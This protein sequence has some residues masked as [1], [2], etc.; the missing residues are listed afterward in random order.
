MKKLVTILFLMSTVFANAQDSQET[1]KWLDKHKK[2]IVKKELSGVKVKGKIE[3]T[4]SY[5]KYSEKM[6][7]GDTY[8]KIINWGDIGRIY[9]NIAD[10]GRYYIT[11]DSTKERFL[12][13]RFTYSE[14]GVDMAVKLAHMAK[15]N[16]A[17]VE[18]SGSD[19]RGV[20]L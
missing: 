18:V 11:I 19:L 16:G 5:I 15:L 12:N 13:I 4:E 9:C 20:K 1:L 7:D 8:E 17:E 14:D 3:M 10:S 6:T 2:H